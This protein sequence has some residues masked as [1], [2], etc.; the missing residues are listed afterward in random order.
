MQGNSSSVDTN[1]S[2]L[3]ITESDSKLDQLECDNH[4]LFDQ[5]SKTNE[6]M[7]VNKETADIHNLFDLNFPITV[8]EGT[9]RDGLNL[10]W[11]ESGHEHEALVLTN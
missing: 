3:S 9:K 6:A 1:T 8:D 4:N 11:V 10:W 7:P 2:N 5:E